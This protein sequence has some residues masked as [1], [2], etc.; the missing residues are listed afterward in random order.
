MP[1][2]AIVGIIG[3]NGAGKSTLFRM[4]SGEETPDA[5]TVDVGETVHLGYVDQSRDSLSDEK[6]VWE[7]ISEGNEIIQIGKYETPS[8]AYVGRF[9]FKGSDQQKL[10]RDLSGGNVTVFTWPSC[11]RLALIFY[12]WMNPP[13]T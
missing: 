13:T 2:G 10:V 6:T 9:N 4:I 8:R 3:G 1:K 5:G 7:E 12:F 11:S